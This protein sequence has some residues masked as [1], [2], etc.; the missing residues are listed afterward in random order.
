MWL[1][2]FFQAAPVQVT[3]EYQLRVFIPAIVNSLVHVDSSNFSR[4]LVRMIIPVARFNEML[5]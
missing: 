5:Y 4:P 1:W 3:G 2:G